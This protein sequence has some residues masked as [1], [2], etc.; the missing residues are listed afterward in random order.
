METIVCETKP[1]SRE[2]RELLRAI[3]MYEDSPVVLTCA[4]WHGKDMTYKVEFNS[5]NAANATNASSGVSAFI[6]VTVTAPR[7]GFTSMHACNIS[8]SPGSQCNDMAVFVHA[9]TAAAG[10]PCFPFKPE[11]Q[12]LIMLLR[13]E[14][15]SR[16]T[17]APPSATLRDVCSVARQSSAA[18]IV[19]MLASTIEVLE[20]PAPSWSIAVK[21]SISDE[22]R[23]ASRDV[24]VVVRYRG[25]DALVAAFRAT[26]NWSNPSAMDVAFSSQ[27]F[28]KGKSLSLLLQNNHVGGFPFG[29][30]L[31]QLAHHLVA[32]LEIY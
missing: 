24:K 11:S 16:L 27:V 32:N 6:Q 21:T 3:L 25:R 10:L 15:T 12:L 8:Y 29:Q 4:S 9:I 22:V 2:Q 28:K 14:D 20:H 19:P 23:D 26:S 31:K 30:A 17:F 13:S 1:K 18:L 7:R 5:A